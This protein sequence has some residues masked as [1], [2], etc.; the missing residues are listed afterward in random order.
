MQN[1]SGL[2]SSISELVVVLAGRM[3]IHHSVNWLL[4]WL[5]ACGSSCSGVV[6]SFS[7][8]VVVGGQS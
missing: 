8:L 1:W 6:A 5:V 2:V 3:W 4:F 7:E